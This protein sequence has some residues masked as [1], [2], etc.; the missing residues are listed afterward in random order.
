MRQQ[1]DGKAQKNAEKL[2]GKL[3]ATDAAKAKDS[4]SDKVESEAKVGL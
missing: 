4:V 3:W 1:Q 2:M